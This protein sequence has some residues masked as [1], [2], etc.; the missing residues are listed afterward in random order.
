MYCLYEFDDWYNYAI[1]WALEAYL[2][3]FGIW[4]IRTKS[5]SYTK[6]I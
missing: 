6:I 2:V 1:H 3:R 4:K 5:G